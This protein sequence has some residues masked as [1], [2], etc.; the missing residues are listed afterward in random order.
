MQISGKQDVASNKTKTV[1]EKLEERDV[2]HYFNNKQD[3]V[4][5]H[6]GGKISI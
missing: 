2:C 5:P 6:N 1:V 4:T 3:T